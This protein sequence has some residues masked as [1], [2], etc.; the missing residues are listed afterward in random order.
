[1]QLDCVTNLK[2][3]KKR[4]RNKA[5]LQHNGEY[6]ERTNSQ[7]GSYSNITL[8]LPDNAAAIP[9]C[10]TVEELVPL[11]HLEEFQKIEIVI[12]DVGDIFMF[13]DHVNT[14]TGDMKCV[15]KA[16]I[17]AHQDQAP[18]SSTVYQQTYANFVESLKILPESSPEESSFAQILQSKSM[19]MSA[20]VMSGISSRDRI[21]IGNDSKVE[22]E[23]DSTFDREKIIFVNTDNGDDQIEDCSASGTGRSMCCV[24][25]VV[26]IADDH[27]LSLAVTSSDV[28]PQSIDCSS[29]VADV[30]SVISS[31][32]CLRYEDNTKDRKK[33]KGT[34]DSSDR[35]ASMT[36]DKRPRIGP[37]G[38]E[39]FVFDEAAVRSSK[40][41]LI[42]LHSYHSFSFF[43]SLE[44][45]GIL[46]L[47]QSEFNL[48]V[49][50]KLIVIVMTSF[51]HLFN[52]ILTGSEAS[53]SCHEI[54]PCPTR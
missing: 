22:V 9:V 2:N 45:S 42:V 37:T 33:K 18:S 10:A 47:I 36:V 31:P 3:F 28:F 54:F 51:S 29:V 43:F 35:A 7:Q 8:S 38:R 30:N 19:H 6:F 26:E 16:I 48:S 40:H 11:L 39:I 24:S 1:M 23:V 49:L 13:D 15:T 53:R 17:P 46:H 44:S 52:C 50:M 21:E 4:G 32:L 14:H 34:A 25:D 12:G 27:I 20:T 5:E 41:F